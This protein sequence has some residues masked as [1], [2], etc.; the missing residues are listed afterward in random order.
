MPDY[1][2]GK[3]Y[4]IWDANYT[5]CYI[6]ST[7]EELSKRMTKHR[8]KY[9]Q[10]LN[11]KYGKTTSFDLFDEFGLQNCKIELL[12]TYPCN[13]RAELLAREGHYIK[14]TECINKQ[15]PTRTKQQYYQDTKEIQR[16]RRQEYREKTKE[17]KKIVD[18][19]YR[20]QNKEYLTTK[21]KEKKL[22]ECGCEVS[23]RNLA[24]HKR[25]P[26]HLEMLSV[27]ETEETK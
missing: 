1:T 16:P 9:K 12:E 2:K 3:V 18:S 20:K 15:I 6:G 5:R 14:N 23:T 4:K 8:E 22:C 13:S 7:C 11:N 17:H 27:E 10:Y 26:K 19:E 21:L 24:S 25:S